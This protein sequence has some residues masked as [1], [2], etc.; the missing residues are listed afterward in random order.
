MWRHGCASHCNAEL[1]SKLTHFLSVSLSNVH[2]WSVLQRWLR[3][4]THDASAVGLSDKPC[5]QNHRGPSR[6]G[7]VNKEPKTYRRPP[8]GA[9]PWSRTATAVLQILHKS[10]IFTWRR[11]KRAPCDGRRYLQWD[12]SSEMSRTFILFLGAIINELNQWSI[13]LWNVDFRFN[14]QWQE[15]S[16]KWEKKE[17]ERWH[18]ILHHFTG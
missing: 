14:R 11:W 2:H 9:A 1:F 18:W 8:A 6:G 7:R 17:V 13:F 12:W 16:W 4:V 10:T 3:A 5:G 15:M